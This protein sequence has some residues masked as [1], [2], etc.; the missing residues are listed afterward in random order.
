MVGTGQE[1][2][3]EFV[4]IGNIVRVRGIDAASGTEINFQAPSNMSAADLRSLAVK[5]L[6]YVLKK[7]RENTSE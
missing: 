6:S 3:I 4:R 1:I 2:L 7:H 5:K